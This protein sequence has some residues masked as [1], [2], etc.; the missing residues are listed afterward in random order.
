MSAGLVWAVI[1]GVVAIASV[2][3]SRRLTGDYFSPAAVV[4]ATWAS[5]FALFLLGVI[6]YPDVAPRT[7]WLLGISSLA[8]VVTAAATSQAI[9]R[10]PSPPTVPPRLV[11]P[12]WC[13]R[14][15][16]IGGLIG[17]TW[18]VWTVGSTLG[19]TAF[20]DRPQRIRFGMAD[21]VISTRFLVLEYLCI[22]T[23]IAAVSIWL[24]GTSLRRSTWALVIAATIGTWIST[25]RTQFFVVALTVY[26]AFVL[27]RGRALRTVQF[28]LA[29][30]IFL[31]VL[32]GYFLLIGAW[33]SKTPATLG[34]EVR[35]PGASRPA[36]VMRAPSGTV[37][38][39]QP[40]PDE[41]GWEELLRRNLQR[42]S[43]I[44]LYATASYRA[45]DVLLDNP[46]PK[47][48]GA[49]VLYPVARLFERAGIVSGGVPP[50]IPPFAPL[51]VN[52][53]ADVMFNAYTY[54]YYPLVDFGPVG[55]VVYAV[56]IGAI[57]GGVY[58]AFRMRRNSPFW[59]LSMGHLSMALAL[60][61]FVNKFNN[62]AAWYI[63]AWS[64][65]PF[66][67]TYAARRL[68]LPDETSPRQV[69]VQRPS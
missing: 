45:L 3:I 16:A 13:V 1:L 21:G 15:L 40:P 69:V 14:A 20:V 29:T 57:A 10:T 59:L 30:L 51:G 66:V 6:P 25:D 38:R 22:A 63:Y 39:R 58:G 49:H 7:V 55:A 56:V 68:G 19:L 43:T 60:T 64:C 62:T 42:V 50:A 41:H 32:G 4:V 53:G 48:Y 12:D 34:V 65:L 46:Q 37:Q 9:D 26:F 11:C 8:L 27:A 5:T 61:V 67:A 52:E 24:T 47:T 28:G 2:P 54:L 35:V 17:I 33:M 31:V 36:L 18:Y 44:F 23:P